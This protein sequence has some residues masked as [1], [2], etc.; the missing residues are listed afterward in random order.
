MILLFILIVVII[1]IISYKIFG[2]EG[3]IEIAGTLYFIN[4]ETFF[5]N[6]TTNMEKFED[7]KSLYSFVCPSKYKEFLSEKSN[8]INKLNKNQLMLLSSILKKKKYVKYEHAINTEILK[9]VITIEHY[10]PQ[11]DIKFNFEYDSTGKM[12][13]MGNVTFVNDLTMYNNLRIFKNCNA[14]A[15]NCV[16][17]DKIKKKSIIPNESVTKFVE[18]NFASHILEE[19]TSE[20]FSN[21]LHLILMEDSVFVGSTIA[22]NE[23]FLRLLKVSYKTLTF[24]IPINIPIIKLYKNK[25]YFYQNFLYSFGNVKFYVYDDN[26]VRCD[27]DCPIP[28]DF[29]KENFKKLVDELLTGEKKKLN[30]YALRDH[31]IRNRYLE[32]I[33]Y[34]ADDINKYNVI[35][36][37]SYSNKIDKNKVTLR[38]L[39]NTFKLETGNKTNVLRENYD[40]NYDYHNLDKIPSKTDIKCCRIFFELEKIKKIKPELYNNI[41]KVFEDLASKLPVQFLTENTVSTISI[42]FF[43]VL[44]I[45]FIEE[46][47]LFFVNVGSMVLIASL[48]YKITGQ[49]VKLI[50]NF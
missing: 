37:S 22:V 17:K 9:N 50:D 49:S 20:S 27:T 25:S 39:I 10:S 8:N 36:N 35:L 4:N 14:I 41:C 43:S 19:Y 6:G 40:Y 30:I 31:R 12:V 26:F 42:D 21:F 13:K 48:L 29:S 34:F 45:L 15:K 5:L 7:I 1:I 3:E 23:I 28:N 38:G 44:K 2:G 47:T 11:K 33:P 32:D 24:K 46:K 18:N 16:F